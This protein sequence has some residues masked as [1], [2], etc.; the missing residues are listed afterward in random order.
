MPQQI[1]QPQ[2]G[3]V[4]V[5][6][7]PAYVPPQDTSFTVQGGTIGGTQPTFNGA[8]LFSGSYVKTGDLVSFRIDVEFDNI[9]SFGTG[10]YYVQLPFV[11]K[12]NTMMR[13][14]CLHRASNG[15]QYAIQG[16]VSAGS[17]ELA[18]WFTAGSG[19]DEVFDHN[20]P[21]TL[22]IQDSFHIAGTY[23]WEEVG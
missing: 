14:G 19:Q 1:I 10:Q 16:H 11:A 20:S 22:A 2:V 23:I 18:L 12:Y 3:R 21:Y 4:R 7:I 5:L 6:S 8:P 13:D 17:N 15:N 9:T